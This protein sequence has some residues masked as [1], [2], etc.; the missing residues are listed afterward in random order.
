MNIFI[1]G[2]RAIN[3]LNKSVIH[4]IKNI[5]DNNYNIIVGDANGVDKAVQNFC[6]EQNYRNVK[7]YATKGK[8][9]NNIGNWYVHN[10]DVPKNLKGFDFYA[11]KDYEMA[12]DADYGLMI[13]NGISKGTLN[14]TINLLEMGKETVLYYSLEE[15]LYVIKSLDGM[16]EFINRCDDKTKKLFIELSHKD[17]QLELNTY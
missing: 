7:I 9:R 12:K 2:P 16:K 5:I 11:A 14:N 17:F 10:V 13:W 8:A 15:R 3:K 1:A 6:Y 4:R